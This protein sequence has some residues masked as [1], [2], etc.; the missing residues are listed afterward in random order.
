MNQTT[1]SHRWKIETS[2]NYNEK[3]KK[4]DGIVACDM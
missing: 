1:Y 3:K 4:S 2:S